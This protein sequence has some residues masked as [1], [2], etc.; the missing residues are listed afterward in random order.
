MVKT[1]PSN[2]EGAGSTPGQ[3]VEIPHALPA[4]KT[5]QNIRQKQY[6]NKFNKHLKNDSKSKNLYQKKE[7]KKSVWT[8][9]PQA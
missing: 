3:G 8:D 6:C 7:R 2:A 1:L 5:K 9:T 4:K